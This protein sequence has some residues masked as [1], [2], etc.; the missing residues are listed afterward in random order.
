MVRKLFRH[1]M[2]ALW[3][4]LLP[5]E[6]ILLAISAFVRGFQIFES[7]H[8]AYGITFGIAVF[9]LVMLNLINLVAVVYIAVFRFYRHL[10]TAEG[11][12]SFT[13]PITP[14]QHIFTKA[15]AA[16]LSQLAAVCVT[17]LSFMIVTAGDVF[18][19]ILRV[20]EYGSGL[21]QEFTQGH[22]VWYIVEFAA[23][24]LTSYISQILLLY[25]CV[26]LGQ[27]SR[28]NRVAMAI[29]AYFVYTVI[30][31]ILSSVLNVAV[32]ISGHEGWFAINSPEELIVFIHGV[33]IAL[34]VW[35][36]VVSA[37]YFVISHTIMRKKLNLE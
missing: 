21:L 18:Y 37:I 3:R 30:V 13:L 5:I 28:K 33:M 22:V 36:L 23:L 25:A 8:L 20:F 6:L 31:Q 10:F 19:E 24:M 1:E 27:L 35:S 34:C 7:D 17:V 9:V 16:L 12:L 14:G 4:I 11:Y 26:C 2:A 29:V 15:S 32:S